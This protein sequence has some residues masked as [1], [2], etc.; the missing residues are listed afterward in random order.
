MLKG[1][2]G[3]GLQG[4]MVSFELTDS[5]LRLILCL[6]AEYSTGSTVQRTVDLESSGMCTDDAV[7]VVC[8]VAMYDVPGMS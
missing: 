6:L 5:F 1:S 4:S 7:A 2:S 8:H 3:V